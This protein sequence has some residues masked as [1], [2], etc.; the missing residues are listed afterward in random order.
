MKTKRLWAERIGYISWTTLIYTQRRNDI[1]RISLAYRIFEFAVNESRS[2]SRISA[3][4]GRT[5]RIWVWK[6][7]PS[8]R[9]QLIWITTFRRVLSSDGKAI[10]TSLFKADLTVFLCDEEWRVESSS[11]NHPVWNHPKKHLP[12]KAAIGRKVKWIAV[13]LL[14]VAATAVAAVPPLL[15]LGTTFSYWVL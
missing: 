6:A 10:K 13:P 9:K 3:A 4:H 8:G 15:P 2:T 11:M 12:A 14:V 1:H 5:F 7:K